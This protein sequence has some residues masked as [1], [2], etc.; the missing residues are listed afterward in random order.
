[1]SA[2]LETRSL[3]VSYGPLSIMHDVGI[4]VPAGEL[5]VVVGPNVPA[6]AP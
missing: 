3:G 4:R 6:R 2:L 5:T 1:M